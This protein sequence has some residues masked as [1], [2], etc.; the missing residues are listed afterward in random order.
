VVNASLDKLGKIDPSTSTVLIGMFLGNTFGFILDTMLGSDEGLREYLWSVPSGMRY[1]LGSLATD[2]FGRYIVTILFDMF[3]TVIL[4]KHF[5]SKLVHVAG[6]SQ[7]GREW[8]ANF[9]VSG[10]I[11]VITFQVYANMTRFQ[12]AVR[13]AGS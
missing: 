13:R 4:F 12:W 7:S 3:F 5:Y 6:F 2:R 11:G 8:I 9:I 1:A 10:F